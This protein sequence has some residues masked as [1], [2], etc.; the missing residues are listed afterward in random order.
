MHLLLE[1]GELGMRNLQ[2][3]L[4]GFWHPRQRLGRRVERRC[5]RSS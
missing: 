2:C 5:Q 3:D 1:K 4:E